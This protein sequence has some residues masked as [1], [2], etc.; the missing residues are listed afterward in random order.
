MVRRSK[1]TVR[2]PSPISRR[3]LPDLLRLQP[4]CAVAPPELSNAIASQLRIRMLSEGEILMRQGEPG[5]FLAFLLTGAVKVVVNGHF[6]GIR[7]C[8]VHLGEMGFLLRSARTST[9]IAHEPSIVGILSYA[10]L[11]SLA[12]NHPVIWKAFADL[13]TQRLR[14]TEKQIAPPN[15]TLR[16][17]IFSSSSAL[18]I[19]NGVAERLK[20]AQR[21]VTVWDRSFDVG[22][23]F[24]S[25]LLAHSRTAD[26]AAVIF[27]AD[28]IVTSKGGTTHAPRDNA[29]FEAGLFYG[30]IGPERTFILCE[31]KVLRHGGKKPVGGG[32]GTQGPG[33][34][35]GLKLLSNLA[36]VKLPTFRRLGKSIDIDEAIQE[37][38]N[39]IR[40]LGP[41]VG[42]RREGG[43]MG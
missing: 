14:E 26:F 13:V 8:G 6:V 1:R 43:T 24:V 37:I 21:N 32:L 28:D 20:G 7:K 10:R 19:A 16:I 41:V 11:A 33:S 2:K 34:L 40:R 22:L 25:Q 29:I 9:V 5:S 12:Q 39:N 35:A 42:R 23:S 17:F 31:Q 18:D 27:A 3:D 4:I 30:S 15:A 36:G 38:E